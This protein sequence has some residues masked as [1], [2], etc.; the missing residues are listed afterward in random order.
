MNRYGFCS[1]SLECG[2][3]QQL[4]GLRSDGARDTNDIEQGDIALPALYFSH[5]A[6]VNFGKVRQCF[7]RK[8][9]F[10][11]P[12]AH[13]GSESHQVSIPIKL[14]RHPLHVGYRRIMMSKRPRYLRPILGVLCAISSSVQWSHLPM[15]RAPEQAL[16]E[17][18]AARS[19]SW[20]FWRFRPHPVYPRAQRTHIVQTQSD[21]ALDDIRLQPSECP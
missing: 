7:L 18:P 14:R 2:C 17:E 6:T 11:A 13:G 5:M 19:R 10:L 16:H 3:A 4:G 15:T 21:N 20:R 8:S 12:S 9:Q 1:G